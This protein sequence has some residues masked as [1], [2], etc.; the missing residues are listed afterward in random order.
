MSTT[1]WNPGQ[2]LRFAHERTQPARDLAARVTLAAA[3]PRIVDLGCG[4]GNSTAVLRERWPD[5]REL[6]GLDYS[7]TMLAAARA[8]HPAGDWQPGDA[9]TWTDPT[10]EGYDLVFSNAVFQ[11]VPGHA[12]L[13]P[14]LLQQAR[15]GGGILAV[16][17]PARAYPPFH[18][19]ILE[20]AD[21]EPGWRER[22]RAARGAVRVASPQEYYD[23]LAPFADRVEIWETRYH[24]VLDNADA[25]VDW[26][27]ST[28]LRPFLDALE[29]DADRA[30]FEDR[31][32]A[33]AA[34]VYPPQ[35]D[36]RVCF[37]FGRLFL[38]AHRR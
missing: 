36:G 29:T 27:R 35:A 16:Q 11:W 14:R 32:R 21:S 26:L 2:Y 5:A 7:E 12:A 30:R 22:T 18:Q 13:F 37:P 9:A 8:D 1:P 31:L 4:P 38:V 24:H 17:M 6:L 3:R 34:T 25:V 28:G 23:W 15:P 33:G 20:T 19:V 10:G